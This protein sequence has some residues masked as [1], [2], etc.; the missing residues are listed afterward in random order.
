MEVNLNFLTEEERLERK[1]TCPMVG[2]NGEGNKNR[3]NKNNKKHGALSSCPNSLN[4]EYIKC[5]ISWSCKGVQDKNED[6]K[7]I[8]M[9]KSAI[10][11]QQS[12]EMGQSEYEIRRAVED[13]FKSV[14]ESSVIAYEADILN[15]CFCLLLKN[16]KKKK[17]LEKKIT[18]T[19]RICN[20]TCVITKKIYN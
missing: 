5:Y 12:N 18:R 2:C 10:I 16:K 8:I 15:Y 13:E 20:Q 4:I 14:H 11:D 19:R 1:V 6:L 7:R 17:K 3:N 9:T